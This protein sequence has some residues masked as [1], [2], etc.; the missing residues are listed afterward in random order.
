MSVHQLVAY[1]TLL[2]VFKV[3]QSGEPGYLANRLGV[4]VRPEQEEVGV[5]ARRRQY[6]IWV[7]FN[8]SI[9]RGS[10]MYRSAKLW[11]S[12]PVDTRKINSVSLFKK[13]AKL[14]IYDNIAIRPP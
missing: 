6:D 1:H 7:N 8:L 12:L 3:W 11:N 13:E 9:A 4:G 14:W 5:M 2:T 10:F